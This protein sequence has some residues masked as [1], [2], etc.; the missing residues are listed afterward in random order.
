MSLD[1]F[2]SSFITRYSISH[3]IMMSHIN[4]QFILKK[5]Q[6]TN[7]MYLIPTYYRNPDFRELCQQFPVFRDLYMDTLRR[8]DLLN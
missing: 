2:Q 8:Y 3:V 6:G 4:L 5:N 7:Q 1:L